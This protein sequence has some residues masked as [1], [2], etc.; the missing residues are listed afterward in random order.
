[1]ATTTKYDSQLFTCKK[2]LT[3]L[4]DTISQQRYNTLATKHQQKKKRD[5]RRSHKTIVQPCIILL[6]NN[7]NTE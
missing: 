6:N 4:L 5:N 3:T 1:M 2:E 7:D